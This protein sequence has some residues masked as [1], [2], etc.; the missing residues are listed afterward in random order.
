[1]HAS[2]W[3]PMTS[4]SLITAPASDAVAPTRR[5]TRP[6]SCC[7]YPHPPASQVQGFS[8]ERG[9]SAFQCARDP[10][11]L[12]LSPPSVER[13]ALGVPM[14]RIAPVTRGCAGKPYT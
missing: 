13:G 10:H 6:M 7:A 9:F 5:P 11:P 1:L 8:S 3:P 14:P 4:S 12:P 2:P